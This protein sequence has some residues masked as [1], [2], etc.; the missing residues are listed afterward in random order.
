MALFLC[1]QVEEW[2]RIGMREGGPTVTR[3]PRGD[4]CPHGLHHRVVQ[5]GLRGTRERSSNVYYMTCNI[6]TRCWHTPP[7]RGVLQVY[8]RYTLYFIPTF[9]I[10]CIVWFNSLHLSASTR[11]INTHSCGGMAVQRQEACRKATTSSWNKWSTSHISD[12]QATACDW[13][14]YLVGLRVQ[15]LKVTQVLMLF[16]ASLLFPAQPRYPPASGIP[17]R[18]SLYVG[19]LLFQRGLLQ[20]RRL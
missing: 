4:L 2:W 19:R 20:E 9:A 11:Y 15:I 5:K 8:M 13:G 18:Y 17:W 7:Y 1:R 6:L 14:L 16:R 3:P 12:S 10:Q